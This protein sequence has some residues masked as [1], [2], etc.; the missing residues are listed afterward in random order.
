MNPDSD[1]GPALKELER[2]DASTATFGTRRMVLWAIR[3]AMGFAVIAVVVHFHPD[4]SWLWWAGAGLAAP[5]P[6]MLLAG[7][8]I[9]GRRSRQARAALLE[10]DSALDEEA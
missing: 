9:I 4:W 3:W 6:I 2:L 7:H 8:W 10:L 1:L 5:M